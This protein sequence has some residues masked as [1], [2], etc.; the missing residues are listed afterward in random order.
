MKLWPFENLFVILVLLFSV[1]MWDL[2]HDYQTL[3]WALGAFAMHTARSHSGRVREDSGKPEDWTSTFAAWM[4]SA[5]AIMAV[6]VHQKVLLG[7][8][9]G[10][11]VL[12]VVYRSLY[13]SKKPALPVRKL[14]LVTR[15]NR[16]SL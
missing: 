12:H 13:R 3:G 16:P 15:S 5:G 9:L 2:P 7:V 8:P 4:A 14:P 6:Q 10:L 1:H 11:W